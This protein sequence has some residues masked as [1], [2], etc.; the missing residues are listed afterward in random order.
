LRDIIGFAVFYSNKAKEI[1]GP[2][3]K[4][5]KQLALKLHSGEV[6]KEECKKDGKIDIFC[7][8]VL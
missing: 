2:R 1:E 8:V 3:N 7:A 5:L 4:M 6:S